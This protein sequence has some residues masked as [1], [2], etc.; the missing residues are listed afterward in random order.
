VFNPNPRHVIKPGGAPI[1]ILVLGAGPAGLCLGYEFK[2]RRLN[3]QI[4]ERSVAPGESWRR[5]PTHLR[6]VSPWKANR[7]PGTSLHL[8]RPNHEVTRAEF[9]QYLRDYARDHALPVRTG[10]DVH[11]V[12]AEWPASFRVHTSAGDFTSRLV[13]NATGYFS[14]AFVPPISGAECTR[15]AQLHVAAFR[16]AEQVGEKLGRRHGRILIVGQ[17]LSAGQTLVELVEAGFEV[18]LSHRAPLRFGAGPLARWFLFRVFPW[19]EEWKRLR[20]GDRAP[21]NAVKMQ[22]GLARRWIERGVVKTFPAIACF[23]PDAVRFTNGARWTPDLVIYATGF[24]PALRH[25]SALNLELDAAS[26]L[27]RLRDWES[28]AVP[29]LFFLGL[30]GVPHFQSRFIRG[31]RRDAQGLAER[32]AARLATAGC[33]DARPATVAAL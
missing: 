9:L 16:D 1:D 29:G 3:F 5:M 14:N 22:G 24:R 7:L 33:A 26:G 8:F 27:P 31:F 6:L 17:R 25:L 32:I 2:Q 4:L 15:I 20:H 12:E 18:A 13:V 19:L 28:V 30:D 10:V 21:A 11:T 23:E